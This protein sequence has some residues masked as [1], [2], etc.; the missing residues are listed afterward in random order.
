MSV[1]PTG[2]EPGSESVS[3]EVDDSGF[4]LRGAVQPDGTYDL[5]LNGQHVW[6]LQPA[7]D[8]TAREDHSRASWP[9]ALVRYLDGHAVVG[10]REHLSGTLLDTCEHWFGTATDR[11]VAVVEPSGHALVL[12]KWG[13]L[14]RPLS[15]E[16][17]EVVEQLMTE[18]VRLLEVLRDDCGVP[19]YVAY[20]TLLGAVRDGRLIGYDNDI[21]L[22]Y[23][24]AHDHPLD[25]AREGFRVQRVLQQRGWTVR[26][27]SAA[28]L[29]VRL[30]MSDGSM[31]FV[32]VFTSHWVDGVFFIPSDVGARLPREAMLPLSTV[33]LLGHEVPAPADPEALLAATYGKN[34]R[35]PDPSFKYETPTWLRRR[36]VGW[37]GGQMKSRKH[38]DQFNATSARRVP[39][40][41]SPFAV[42]VADNYPSQRPLVDVGT[43][44][45]RDAVLFA[46]HGRSVLGIDY[47][48]GAVS[49]ATRLFSRK[50]LSARF[51]TLNLYDLRATL[52]MGARLSREEQPV[53]VYARFTMHTLGED[54]RAN[55]LR[56]AS[57]ALRRGGRF[58]AE[59]RTLED[60]DQ[61][62]IF[63]AHFRRYLPPDLV[64]AEI[65]AAGG[66]VVHREE[67][68]GLA[69]LREEDPHVC[70][71][72]AEWAPT[73]VEGA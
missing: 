10:L 13:R 15:A 62:H 27:G 25:V 8:M 70:R 2:L 11:E 73:P 7:R 12:D 6:S 55:L 56:L 53:D 16:G 36:L 66:A 32:D 51:V 17:G 42:W 52:A 58:F 9:K 44:T 21:D 69:V 50:E 65:E 60:K 63:G 71:L 14:T 22:A 57:M 23:V 26:R 30:R 4:V 40:R 34:W 41:P 49:R 33:Q 61:P 72:V 67:G 5:L 20:G 39:S 19:A 54:G 29:N 68:H 1:V 38:W 43:G 46:G 37:F 31:R 47:S 48:N 64:V 18:V 59:F 24:S 3:L 35:T 28:R 45:A